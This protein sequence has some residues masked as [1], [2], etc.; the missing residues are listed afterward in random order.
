[1]PS[2]WGPKKNRSIKKIL[3]NRHPKPLD[4]RRWN[5]GAG[6]EAYGLKTATISD[7]RPGDVIGFSDLSSLG[8]WINYTTWGLPGWGLSH[9][10]I[11]ATSPLDDG[12]AVVFESTSSCNRPCLVSKRVVR[13]VQ[14]H[15]LQNRIADY[16]GRA[17]VY[18]LA[19]PLGE[20]ASRLL[21]QLCFN[22]CGIPYDYWGAFRSRSLGLGWLARLIHPRPENLRA[23]YCSEFVAE[24]LRDLKRLDV[25]NVS[26]WAPNPLMREALRQK[27]ITSRKSLS[28]GA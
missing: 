20:I 28:Q 22:D 11:V 15:W 3:L 23:Y 12:E 26:E 9:I 7:V 4:N 1:M 13:G 25:D 21:L 2:L 18:P 10:A 8:R 5:I 16:H 6:T 19:E 27:T 14:C 17:W 24:R